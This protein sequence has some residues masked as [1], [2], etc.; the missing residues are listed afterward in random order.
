MS[1]ANPTPTQTPNTG[2]SM[3]QP[4]GRRRRERRRTPLQRVLRSLRKFRRR[5]FRKMTPGLILVGI[6]VLFVVVFVAGAVIATDV[7]NN[8]NS[9]WQSLERV[10][11]GIGT[12]QGTELTLTDF[13][14]LQAAIVDLRRSTNNAL[15]RAQWVEPLAGLVPDGAESIK[16]LYAA[17]EMMQAAN[18]MLVGLE[19]TLFYLVSGDEEEVVASRISSGERLVERLELG[20]DNFISAEDSLRIAQQYLNE[21]DLNNVSAEMLF[22]VQELNDY[23]NQLWEINQI[24]V[25]SPDILTAMLGLDGQRNYLILSQNSDELRPSG[26]YISTWGWLNVSNG[27]IQRYGYSATTTTSPR[28]PSAS[29]INQVNL[30]DWWLRYEEPIYAAWDGSWYVDYPKTAQM[31][32]DY[33]EAGGNPHTPVHG[34][35]AIDI[36]GFEYLL[37]AIGEVP[38]PGYDV[39]VTPNNFRQLVYDI[40]STGAFVR[41][42]PHKD[43]VAAI[44]EAIFAEWQAIRQEDSAMLLGN[45][46][47]AMQEKHIML[48]FVDP[49]LNR[50]VNLLGWSGRQEPALEHDYLLVADANRGGNKSNRSIFRDITYDVGI[51]EDGAVESNLSVNYS[52]PAAVGDLDPA[53]SPEF[54]G[55]LVYYNQMQVH[56][57]DGAILQGTENITG[58][59]LTLDE[60]AHTLFTTRFFLDYDETYR[61]QYNYTTPDIV[62]TLGSYQRYRLRLQ[63]QP[64]TIADTASVQVRLPNSVQIIRAEPRPD[65]QYNLRNEQVLDF[66]LTLETDEWVEVVFQSR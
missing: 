7:T 46:L 54:H 41:G 24:L 8:L 37:Q 27:R 48:Y 57:P 11:R 28:P 66:S 36:V 64:G 42:T 34:V 52:Y 50:S 29:F 33:Y 43:F 56:V 44:Y 38:V 65:A 22:N 35:F 53:V 59:V 9:S 39:V 20:R 62:E 19:P 14:R 15:D 47:T 25:Q 5:S 18:Q 31:A 55:P 21:L 4:L 2:S 51:Q 1:E 30:P 60:E 32:L 49:E 23:Y 40:R 17:D 26:G 6:L 63:K 10:M 13:N 3:P 58:R 45:L 61:V 12:K 16:A